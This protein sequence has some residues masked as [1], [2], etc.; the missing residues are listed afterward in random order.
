VLFY[1]FASTQG[2]FEAF[3]SLNRVWHFTNYTVAHAHLTVYG[4]V[5]F[6]IWGGVYALLPR[7]TGREPPHLAIGVHFWL[8]LVGVLVYGFALMIGG[9]L[10]GESW[11]RGA[12]FLDSVTMMAPYWTGRAVGGTLMFLSHLVFAYNVWAMRPGAAPA[13]APVTA[14]AEAA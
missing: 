2:T 7:L 8:A 10:Q 11:M 12:P 14:E 4:F 13:Q 5:V 6:L 1:F 3:R 9:T